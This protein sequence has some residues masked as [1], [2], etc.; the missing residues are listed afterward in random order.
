MT[1][2]RS[3]LRPL[4][5]QRL[6][7]AEREALAAELRQIA[8][9]QAQLA[10]AERREARRPAAQ[11]VTRS[12]RPGGRP[13]AMYVYLMVREDRT[14]AE[15]TYTLRIGRGV[16]DAYQALRRDP[17]APLRLVV[18]VVGAT[19]RLTEDSSGYA[20]T[21]NVGGVRVNVSGSRDTL[22]HLPAGVR[23]P[24]EAERG[25]IVAVLGKNA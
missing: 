2:P 24:A 21:V 8:D 18:Q 16:F 15:P 25:A 12:G 14:R 22:G 5:A 23:W 13:G 4:L 7:P 19:L 3:L 10:Q 1:T 11:R 17:S 20:V 9:E 6:T